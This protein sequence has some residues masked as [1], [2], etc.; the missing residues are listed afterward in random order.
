M[1]NIDH[2]AACGEPTAQMNCMFSKKNNDQIDV[3]E[4]SPKKY[5]PY[6]NTPSP[7]A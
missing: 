2:I 7:T 6:E 4:E 1:F 5:T 3:P